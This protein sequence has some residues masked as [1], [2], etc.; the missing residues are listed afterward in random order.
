ML[1]TLATL[2]VNLMIM[3]DVITR[4]GVLFSATVLP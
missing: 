1:I 2:R 3:V 4:R